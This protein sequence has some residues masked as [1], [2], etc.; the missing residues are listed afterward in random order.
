MGARMDQGFSALGSLMQDML[1]EL[2]ATH[3]DVRGMR[4]TVEALT[5]S[6]TAHDAAINDL[7]GRVERLERNAGLA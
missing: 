4:G 1:A 5:R 2:T 3:A 7:T 6:D